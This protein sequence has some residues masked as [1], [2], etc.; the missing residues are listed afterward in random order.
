[1][2]KSTRLLILRRL[3]FVLLILA[4]NILQNTK[5]F[6]F[7]PFGLRAFLLIP[8]IV[9]IGMFERS[10]A[11]ALLG[12]LAGAL[13]DSAS[14]FWDGYNTLFLMLTAAVC[15]LL[16]NILMRNHLATAMILSTV[17]GLIYSLMYVVLVVVARGL[18]SSWYLLWSFYLPS[19]LY[20]AV[21]TPV[22]YIIVRAVM[23]ATT[24]EEKY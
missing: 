21:F 1:M 6:F 22:F 17:T 7:E 16:I 24:V 13:W 12:V 14:A 20:T 18:D 23:R 19:A 4:V 8:L 3:G 10:Y 15:G 9:S 2:R 11:G 5:G